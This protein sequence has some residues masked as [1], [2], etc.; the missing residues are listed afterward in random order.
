MAIMTTLPVVAATNPRVAI[1][2]TKGT[3]II[4][5]FADKAPISVKNFLDYVDAK[6][7]NGTI[8]HRVIPGFMVQGGGFTKDFAKKPTREPIK[9]EAKNGVANKRGTLAMARTAI[10]DSATAQFFI[11]VADNEFLNHQND[12]QYGYAV[13]GQVIDG[14]RIV[15]AI[16]ASECICPSRSQEQCTANIPPGMRDVPKEAIIIIKASRVN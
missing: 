5:L 2:T 7:Y 4:E 8:F 16:V 9:N 3:I 6:F 10:V 15:D 13:F 12:S 11:N 1:E 14:M